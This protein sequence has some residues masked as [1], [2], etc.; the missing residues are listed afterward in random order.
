MRN[1]FRGA[2][3]AAFKWVKSFIPTD[4]RGAIDLGAVLML[5]IGMV[6]ISIGIIMFKTI[7]TAS[8]DV[9]SENLTPFTGTE[10]MV[11]VGPTLIYVA[12]LA[13]GVVTGFFGV[14][15]LIKG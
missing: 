14:K 4:E 12:F 2:L 9:L 5:G 15:R 6:F 7:V 13:A 11:K 1:I 8:N 10:D 3:K